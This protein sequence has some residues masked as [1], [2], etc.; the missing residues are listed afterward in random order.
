MAERVDE[1]LDWEMKV[2]QIIECHQIDH[3]KRV[4]LHTKL[5]GTNYVLVDDISERS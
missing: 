3:E 5:S 2:E 1:Y 4:F